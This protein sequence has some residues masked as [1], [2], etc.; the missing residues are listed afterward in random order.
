[1]ALTYQMHSPVNLLPPE[2]GTVR[3]EK[4]HDV[5]HSLV[6]CYVHGSKHM[7]QT[8]FKNWGGRNVII[9]HY[10]RSQIVN[11][12]LLASSRV[13][14]HPSDRRHEQLGSLSTDFH[15][16][17]SLSIFQKPVEKIQVS[18]KSEKN[19]VYFTWR[20]MYIYAISADSSYNAICFTQTWHSKS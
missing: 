11:K 9:L 17:W 13:S 10:A 5:G 8:F 18:L 15:E 7:R 1:V 6:T 2:N 4:G 20:P 19:N 14:V 12:R 3:M 16:I